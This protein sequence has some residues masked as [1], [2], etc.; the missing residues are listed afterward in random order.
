MFRHQR[1]AARRGKVKR[2]GPDAWTLWSGRDGAA[3]AFGCGPHAWNE[4]SLVVWVRREFCPADGR[5]SRSSVCPRISRTPAR[6]AARGGRGGAQ[7]VVSRE[8]RVASTSY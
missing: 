2:L 7:A 5:V 1:G 4:E 6:S 3:E 8:Y